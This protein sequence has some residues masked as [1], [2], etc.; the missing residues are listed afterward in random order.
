MFTGVAGPPAPGRAP[1]L[2]QRGRAALERGS[3]D[4]RAAL[5]SCVTALARLLTPRKRLTI[6]GQGFA[7]RDVSEAYRRLSVD[8]LGRAG[9][10]ASGPDLAKIWPKPCSGC[11]ETRDLQGFR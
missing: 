7:P 11:G 3:C 6:L 10:D 1:A 8:A 4:V 5:T 2:R 9:D